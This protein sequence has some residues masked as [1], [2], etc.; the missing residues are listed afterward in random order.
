MLQSNAQKQENLNAQ[1]IAL[2][3]IFTAL[4]FTL[5]NTL[6]THTTVIKHTQ[7]SA[8][9]LNTQLDIEQQLAPQHTLSDPLNDAVD[10]YVIVVEEAFPFEQ[11]IRRVA[12]ELEIDESLVYAVTKAESS[13]RAGVQSHAGAIG[14]MQVIAHAAGRDAYYRLHKKRETPTP[15]QLKDPYTNLQLG[16]TYLKLL[17]EHHFGHITDDKLKQMLVLAAY[18]WGP[19]NVKRKLLAKNP[20]RNAEE[21]K[22]VLWTKAPRETYS[23]VNKVLKYQTQFSQFDA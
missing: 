3:I 18:N 11:Q 16:S 13:F 21:M 10:G 23:Y 5:T 12:N 1:I 4:L 8:T 9:H 22:W 19:V 14:L 2:F 17:E 15:E 20:P 7:P 6:S